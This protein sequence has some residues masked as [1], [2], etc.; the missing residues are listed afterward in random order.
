MV[1]SHKSTVSILKALMETQT[2]FSI[3]PDV[4][5]GATRWVQLRQEDDGSFTPLPA[6]VKF[7]PSSLSVDTYNKNKSREISLLEQIAEI[8][9]ETLITFHE[10]PIENSE[11]IYSFGKATNFLE[12]VLPKIENSEA[13]AAVTLALVLYR[14]KK[15]NWAIEK[16]RNSSTTEDGEFGWP[17]IMPKRDAADWLYES[18]SSRTLKEPLVGKVN[19]CFLFLHI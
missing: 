12:N 8:T 2:Y 6:D 1:G 4:I 13:V 10:Y 5:Q 15:A 19:I 17:H 11:E 14:S 3:D 16:L 7:F 18:E 9:A